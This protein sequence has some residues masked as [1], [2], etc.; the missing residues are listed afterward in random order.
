MKLAKLCG[1]NTAE[2]GIKKFDTQNVLFVKRFDRELLINEDGAFKVLKK[3][4]IDGCQILDLD[5]SMKYEKKFMLILEVM[6]I[7]G[8]YLNLLNYQQI[9]S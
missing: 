7:L 4:I 1:L 6:R 2:V 3:H 9:K 5:V 8:I